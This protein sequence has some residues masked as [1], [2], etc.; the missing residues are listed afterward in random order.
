MILPFRNYRRFF[1]ES[2]DQNQK[3]PMTDGLRVMD[4]DRNA[5]QKCITFVTSVV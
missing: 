4:P 1:L 3:R 5:E 2:A